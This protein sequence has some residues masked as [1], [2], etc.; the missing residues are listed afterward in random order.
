MHSSTQFSSQ[1]GGDKTCV[2]RN[3]KDDMTEIRIT[4]EL[5]IINT[6]GGSR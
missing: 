3:R 6:Q 4:G 1:E 5:P 2:A